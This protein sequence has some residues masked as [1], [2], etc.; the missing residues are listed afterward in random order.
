MNTWFTS[1]LHFFHKNILKYCA[2][3][4]PFG[5][6]EA[7]NQAI[8]DNWNNTVDQEDSVWVLGDVS[9][10]PVGPTVD[11]LKSLKGKK[12]LI[13]GNHDKKLLKEQ[14]FRDCFAT[15]DN[16]VEFRYNHV[17][18]CM[19]HYPIESWNEKNHGSLMLHGHSHGNPLQTQGRILDV[20]VDTN[21]LM[22][23]NLLDVYS[24]LT[25]VPVVH[26]FGD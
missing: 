2:Q 15:I 13:V 4:R 9:F 11:I 21:K 26:D 24:S 5:S 1:D 25:Q 10:G 16:Y 8:I 7:M 12:H 18:I 6:V 23:Y 14:D 22:P 19:M 20:G 17:K 3:S